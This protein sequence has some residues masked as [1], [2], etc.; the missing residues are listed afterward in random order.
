[1]ELL[2]RDAK[3]VPQNAVIRYRYGLS[4][5][6]HGRLDEAEKELVEA[7]RLSPNTP[8]FVLAVALLYQKQGRIDEAIKYAKALVELRRTIRH[9]CNC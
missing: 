3:F 8:D 5:Y 6:L 7:A 9:I 1:M 2:A 4:L